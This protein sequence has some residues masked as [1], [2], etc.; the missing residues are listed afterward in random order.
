VKKALWAVIASL[1]LSVK[2]NS[3]IDPGGESFSFI[4]DR[5]MDSKSSG[6]GMHRLH[7]R[8]AKDI[9]SHEL[10]AGWTWSSSWMLSHRVSFQAAH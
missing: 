2:W 3:A 5:G 10:S 7:E 8:P 4:R 9:F 1:F 6:K